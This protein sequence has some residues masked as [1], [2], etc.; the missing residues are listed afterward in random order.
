MK[1][2]QGIGILLFLLASVNAWA[3]EVNTQTIQVIVSSQSELTA[4]N[5]KQVM[6]LF[7]GRSRSFPN[8]INAKAFDH[9]VDSTIR[10]RFF[11]SL[12]GKS[13][14]DIDAYWARLRYSGRASP[15]KVI[16]NMAEILKEVSQNLHAIAY[17]QGQDPAELMQQDIV[18]VHT[19][20]AN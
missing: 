7:L 14:S 1:N 8:G 11:E 2:I 17:I 4:L 18:V 12:T 10:A 6:G 13:I 5:R 3:E 19:I 15:P 20:D 16:D 9:E